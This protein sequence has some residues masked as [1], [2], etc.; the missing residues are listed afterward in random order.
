MN[1]LLDIENIM[2]KNSLI[3]EDI[4][5]DAESIAVETRC[6]CVDQSII[7]GL[8]LSY[9]EEYEK[10]HPELVRVIR[11]RLHE[12]Q[13][14]FQHAQMAALD[15]IIFSTFANTVD[16]AVFEESLIQVK[17]LAHEPELM[18]MRKVMFD[19]GIELTGLTTGGSATA[20][21][22]KTRTSQFH[23]ACDAALSI[24]E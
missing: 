5:I 22:L 17:P 7:D 8:V 18:R 16:S 3:A 11:E 10:N 23:R 21:R 2:N 24:N 15:A 13:E 6:L 20:G 14:F 12:D 4:Q 19:F 1:F 9:L